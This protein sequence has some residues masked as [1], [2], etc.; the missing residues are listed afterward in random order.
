MNPLSSDEIYGNWATLLLTTD[1]KGNIDFSKLD[2]E[3][4]ILIDTQPN[5]IYSNGTAGEFYSQTEDEFFQI[6]EHLA[7]KCEKAKIPFQIG[8]SHMS[9]QISLNRL[10]MIKHLKPGAVQ[11][12]L[13]DWFPPT[14]EECVIFFQRIALEAGDISLV[15]YNPP[16]SKKKLQPE[17]WKDLKREIPTLM[18]VKVFDHNSDLEWYEKVRHNNKGISV[19]IPGHNLATAITLGAQG[20]YSNVSCL[21]PLVAQKWF[22]LM[23]TDMDQALELEKRIKIF[24]TTM[25]EPFITQQHF[26][27]HAC[28]RFMALVGGWADIGVSLRWPYKSIPEEFAKPVREKAKNIIPEFFINNYAK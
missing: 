7:T 24:M 12:I 4:D 6:S 20:A 11:V 16:H 9:P 15:L 3:I 13:P 28:D 5:G 21:N 26:P 2:D 14:I 1:K 10:K 22:N 19:F 27:N 17:E 25:I 23:K 8:I 18:G